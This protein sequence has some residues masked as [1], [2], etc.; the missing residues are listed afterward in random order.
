MFMVWTVKKYCVYFTT[1]TLENTVYIS[2]LKKKHSHW[3]TQVGVGFYILHLAFYRLFVFFFV[4]H[5]LIQQWPTESDVIY[6]QLLFFFWIWICFFQL[7]SE[8]WKCKKR[9]KKCNQKSELKIVGIKQ[10]FF[11]NSWSGN[12]KP[13]VVNETVWLVSHSKITII[14][15][16]IIKMYAKKIWRI[17]RHSCDRI[18]IV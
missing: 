18:Y 15:H 17:V 8:C 6:I 1:N 2:N 13:K 5:L 11:F 4:E 12:V 10:S 9:E 3:V 14:Y 7:S 16:N